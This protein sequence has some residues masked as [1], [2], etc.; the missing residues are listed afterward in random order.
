M[1]DIVQIIIFGLIVCLCFLYHL[2]KEQKESYEHESK[3]CETLRQKCAFLELMENELFELR[4]AFM[5]GDEKAI[6]G[7][8]AQCV[9]YY[10]AVNRGGLSA[11]P[12]IELNRTI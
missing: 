5:H 6:E 1:D 4:L 3:H 7:Y 2:Y 12:V 8:R 11:A 9:A 10:E